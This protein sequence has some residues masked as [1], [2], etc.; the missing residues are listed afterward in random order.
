MSVSSAYL[1]VMCV[2]H[3]SVLSVLCLLSVL[4]VC[5]FV[6]CNLSVTH[7]YVCHLFICLSAIIMSACLSTDSHLSVCLSSFG[8]SVCQLTVICLSVLFSVTIIYQKVI[9]CNF[10]ANLSPPCLLISNIR[11]VLLHLK[12]ETYCSSINEGKFIHTIF[13]PI[14]VISLKPHPNILIG[15]RPEPT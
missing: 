11:C 2:C 5:L 8:L 13:I 4:S 12:A 14:N 15:K 6:T 10:L 1:S 7:L 3:L 9:R